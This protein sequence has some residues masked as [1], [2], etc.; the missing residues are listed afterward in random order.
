MAQLP[1]D[2]EYKLEAI[3]AFAD[4][5]LNRD[6]LLNVEYRISNAP[7]V[8]LTDPATNVDV[9]KVLVT[10]GLLLVEKRRERKLQKLV[11]VVVVFHFF[12]FDFR[13]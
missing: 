13:N 3:K 10:D 9:V 7:F 2:E 8:T 4:D 11:S 6:L 1:S 12:Y 5:T